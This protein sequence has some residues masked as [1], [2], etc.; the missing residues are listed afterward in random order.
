METLS[1]FLVMVNG[2]PPH[3]RPVIRTFEVTLLRT[4]KYCWSSR[5]VAG[6]LRHH[7]AHVTPWFRGC[8]CAAGCLHGNGAPTISPIYGR[9]ILLIALRTARSGD[10]SP[11]TILR[12]ETHCFDRYILCYWDI[13]FWCGDFEQGIMGS[14]IP[15]PSPYVR[16]VEKVWQTIKLVSIMNSFVIIIP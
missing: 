5:G 2:G 6:D 8:A 1:I 10:E 7:G 11:R 9:Y 12:Q 13:L 14:P 4:W 3:K 16:S 15:N